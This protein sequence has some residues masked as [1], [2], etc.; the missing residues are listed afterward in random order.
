MSAIARD[1]RALSR[2]GESPGGHFERVAFTPRDY[3]ARGVFKLLLRR[4]GLK[5]RT[6]G[7]GNII[8]RLAGRDPRAPAVV[9]GSHLDTVPRGGRFDGT[10][11][12]VAGLEVARRIASEATLTHPVEIV[13]FVCEESSRFG[14]GTLGSKAVAGRMPPVQILDLADREGRR[15]EDL[16]APR[17]ITARTMRASRWASGSVK[18]YLELHIEQGRVLEAAGKRLGVVT[19]I[20]A[21][22]RLRVTFDG[23]QDHSGTTPMRL[24]RDALAGAAELIGAVERVALARERVVATVGTCEVT[25]GAFNVVPG[26]ATLGVDVRSISVT[27]KS[28]AVKAIGLDAERIAAARGLAVTTEVISDEEPVAL[29]RALI[30]LLGGICAER[31]VEWLEMPSGA[32][33]DAM[34][35]ARLAPAG[36]LFVPSRDGI[37]HNA[38]EWS[39]LEDVALGADVLL[40]AARRLAA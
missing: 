36:M 5:V 18:A 24:R 21:P 20:A 34:E 38:D 13:M 37:S 16:V 33:H 9:L 12:I 30:V 22:T 29:D 26:R 17:G 32:G 3:G 40:E 1:F 8:G 4:A 35:I 2:A 10:A 39:D 25:P 6:D 14:M 11:G 7:F 23:R 28:D 31:G 27:D 15:L 19:A